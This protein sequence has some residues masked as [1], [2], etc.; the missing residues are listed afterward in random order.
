MLFES[1]SSSVQSATRNSDGK[2]VAVKTIFSGDGEHEWRIHV[3]L[4]SKGDVGTL[5]M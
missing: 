5:E 1:D 4:N 2:R 3:F